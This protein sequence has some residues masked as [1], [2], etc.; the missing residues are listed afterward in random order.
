MYGQQPPPGGYGPPPGGQPPGYGPPPGGGYGQP[1]GYGQMQ[2][3]YG[4]QPGF[5]PPMPPGQQPKSKFLAILLNM[6]PAMFGICGI[7][8]FYTG[9]IGIGIAQLLTVGG[10]GIWQ[11]VDLI[12]IFTGSYKDSSG[13]PLVADH[14]V[15]RLM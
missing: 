7:H 10:C 6:L 4:P 8:R 13:Q 11:L 5:G 15:R 14:P 2:P 9:H 1:P 12:F 3:G